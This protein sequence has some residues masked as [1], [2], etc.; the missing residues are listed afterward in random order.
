[1]QGERGESL[2]RG[3]EQR[4]STYIPIGKKKRGK[5]LSILGEKGGE[6]KHA[7]REKRLIHH[8]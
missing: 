6:K 1:L 2:F 7:E 4:E 3:G 8:F 5:G